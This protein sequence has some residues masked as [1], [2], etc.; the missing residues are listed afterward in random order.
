MEMKL[1]SNLCDRKFCYR[2]DSVSSLL[3]VTSFRIGLSIKIAESPNRSRHHLSSEG[4]QRLIGRMRTPTQSRKIHEAQD[5]AISVSVK[6]L[7]RFM[8]CLE[9]L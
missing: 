2:L 8:G 6:K 1:Q 9:K 7:P 3:G 5:N 4:S